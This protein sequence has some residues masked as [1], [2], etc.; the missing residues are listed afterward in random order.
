VK[1]TLALGE[2]DTR[3]AILIYAISRRQSALVADWMARISKN[4]LMDIDMPEL[5]KETAKLEFQYKTVLDLGKFMYDFYFKLSTMSFTLNGLLLSAVSFFLPQ[6]GKLPDTLFGTGIRAVAIVGLIYNM[7]ALSTYVSLTILTGNLSARF[8]TLDRRLGLGVRSC[9]SRWS[10]RLGYLSAGLTM[11][12]FI[13]WI[14]VWAYLIRNIP[15]ANSTAF[16]GD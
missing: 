8:A 4:P 12:F 6:A 16:N 1:G 14:V 2:R 5:G 10:D 7:G 11:L 15:S 13:A 3:I 9:R